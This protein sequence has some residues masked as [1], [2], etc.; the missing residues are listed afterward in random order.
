MF[1]KTDLLWQKQEFIRSAQQTIC[2][3]SFAGLM[4][5][6]VFTPNAAAQ[7]TVP[8]T[9]AAIRSF[10]ETARLVEP[11]VVNIDTKFSA[12]E[13]TARNEQEKILELLQRRARPTGSVGSGFIV[14]ADGYI[15]TNAH[16]VEGVSRIVVRLDNGERYA[17]R[18]IGADEETDL[19]VIKI[20]APK[21]LPAV[22]FGNSDAA[23]VGDWVLAVGSPFGLDKSVTAG[24]ISQVGRETP[25]ATSFQKF[26]QTDAAI[27]RGNSGGPLVNLKGQVIGINSQI[28]TT[29]GDYNG[30][31]F[32][33]PSN[34]ALY[35]Y[36]Q[37]RA[38]GRVQRGYLGVSLESVRAAF[39]KI[40]GLSD[41]KG[42]IVTDLRA[43]NSPAGKAGILPNDLITAV[44]GQTVLDSQDLIAKIALI[45]PQTA[46]ELTV[47]RENAEGKFVSRQ[48]SVILGER[49][50]SAT[51]QNAA[52]SAAPPAKGLGLSVADLT[53]Q[54]LRANGLPESPE[55][56]GVFVNDINP[57]GALSES[58]E[59]RL[60]QTI[61][62]GDII[63]R[64]NRQKINNAAEFAQFADKLQ[65]GDA[66][67]IYAVSY[68]RQTRRYEPK[69]I[70]AIIQ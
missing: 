13:S 32:A 42:A 40:Y 67:V 62:E 16:V 43:E 53:P 25:S 68:N 57:N 34:D 3:L 9:S 65:S 39:A 60:S 38:N 31:G 41:V 66:V 5:T 47:W 6:A 45:A 70:Q 55:V 7:Q 15:L 29:T 52:P 58:R 56:R 23:Q 11:S 69:I 14:S 51:T 48:V 20:D 30:I 4:L 33:L 54:L 61:T 2:A 19:A 64:L 22:E 36:R 18:V 44:N 28:A 8:E 35:V 17:G 10:S 49:P 24:I 46:A 27:N 26:I 50:S 63:T 37:I 1:R 12:P 21:P 59:S